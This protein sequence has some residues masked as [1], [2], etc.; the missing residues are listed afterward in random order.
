MVERAQAVGKH[1][2]RV[3]IKDIEYHLPE[4]TVTN[5][6]LQQENPSWDMSLVESRFGVVKRHI[7]GDDET[8]LDLAFQACNKLFSKNKDAQNEIDGIIF[9]TQ[10]PDYIM[11]P[12][13]CI[14]HKMLD[15]PEDVFAFDFNLACSGYIYG[16]GLAQ[17]L[18]CASLAKNVL[19][20]TGDTYSKYIHKQDRS[21]RVLFGD[22]A[23]VSW[24]TAS[25][26]TEGIIDIQCSTSGKG[27][28]KFIIPAGGCRVQRCEKTS[29]PTAGDSGNVRTLENI[30]MD[31]LGILSFVNSKV[32]E[33]IHRILE[34]NKLTVNDIDLFIFH[35]ASKMALDSL[36]RLLK[37]KPDR[38]YRNLH[39]V[40]NTVSASIPI[41]LKDVLEKGDLSRGH[42]VL[43]SGF[44]VGLSWGTA[45]VEI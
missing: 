15:L 28:E 29:I 44:G 27:Y 40:G 17:G 21:T 39:E 45:L 3:K 14:L 4:Y 30:H 23:A 38:V 6:A 11:P 18:I 43:L 19:L 20:V 16:L 35:Q 41:A 42:K 25:D 22:G 10:S 33:Q 5:E 37:L 7:A 34:P 8:A 13:S 31:G 2:C 26:S 1:P 32:P 9:C 36:S 12:N 24:I